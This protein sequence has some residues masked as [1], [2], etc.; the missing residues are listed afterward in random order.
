[1]RYQVGDSALFF[2]NSLTA[3]TGMNTMSKHNRIDDHPSVICRCGKQQKMKRHTHGRTFAV[4]DDELGVYTYGYTCSKCGLSWILGEDAYIGDDK[5]WSQ[6]SGGKSLP[7]KGKTA[8]RNFVM[9]KSEAKAEEAG[10]EDEEEEEEVSNCQACACTSKKCLTGGEGSGLD[11][12]DLCDCCMECNNCDRKAFQSITV[13]AQHCID[14]D[15][16]HDMTPEAIGDCWEVL[17][18]EAHCKYCRY[19]CTGCNSRFEDSDSAKSC[20]GHDPEPWCGYDELDE[21]VIKEAKGSAADEKNGPLQPGERRKHWPETNFDVSSP[22][23][24]EG[25]EDPK[26]HVSCGQCGLEEK[27]YSWMTAKTRWEEIFKLRW[28]P[29]Y[30]KRN[31][32][33]KVAA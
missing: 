33:Q 19:E 12:D 6:G 25:E 21:D 13:A 28:C 29:G 2:S 9:V 27:Y 3:L 14:D 31:Q 26:Y 32:V 11:G 8:E 15:H 20:C 30:D 18:A 4:V 1:M 7:I 24:V 22:C 5:K 10:E 17:D 23:D 16:K